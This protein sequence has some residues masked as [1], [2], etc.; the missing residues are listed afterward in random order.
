MDR[1]DLL[2]TPTLPVTAFPAGDDHP[3]QVAGVPATTYSWLPFT[4]PF[5]LTGLPAISVP[6]GLADGLPVGLQLVGRWRDDRSVLAAA[7]AFEAA[8]PWLG[9]LA[10]ATAHLLRAG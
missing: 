8:R 5:N 7:A 10:G 3:A 6:A 4:L 9:S 1:F 2:V